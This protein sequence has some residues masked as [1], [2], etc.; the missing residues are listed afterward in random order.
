MARGVK[1]PVRLSLRVSV[2][3]EGKVTRVQ[4]TGNGPPDA[5]LAKCLMEA[6]QGITFPKPASGQV[7]LTVQ[8][9][10]AGE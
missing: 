8:F 1:P 2:S 9:S 6:V 7:E 3:S 10:L 5:T 4:W